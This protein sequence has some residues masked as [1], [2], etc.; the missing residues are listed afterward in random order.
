MIAFLY[1]IMSCENY[2]RKNPSF[3]FS[4]FKVSLSVEVEKECALL[5]H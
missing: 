2:T 1:K 5:R 3:Y 4:E